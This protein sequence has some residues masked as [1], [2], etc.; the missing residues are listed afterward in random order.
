M[1]KI[2]VRSV[3]VALL[4]AACAL[5]ALSTFGGCTADKPEVD[6]DFTDLAGIDDK[7]DYFSSKLKVLGTLG[8]GD[9]V[10][11]RY[12]ATPRFRGYSFTAAAG[13][14]VDV[15]VKS[16]TGDALAWV[17]DG[18]Y[19]V[20]AKNDDASADTYDAHVVTTLPAS[21]VA[22]GRYYVIFRDYNLETRYFNVSLK[23]L[24]GAPGDAAWRGQAQAEIVRLVNDFSPLEAFKVDKAT[25]PAA[26]KARFDASAAVLETPWAYQVPV[27]GK[28]VYLVLATDGSGE[29]NTVVADL[30]DGAGV[31]FA[32]GVG[33]VVWD[34]GGGLSWTLDLADPT[35]C[36]CERGAGQPATCTWWADGS[37]TSSSEITCE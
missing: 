37:R 1:R 26:A 22:G 20:V 34:G 19:K 24:A 36:R 2:R 13:D 30:V 6:E 7:G 21:G 12:T 33:H 23:K 10:R 27:A 28:P 31:W 29:G 32:H 3:A 16:T 8:D 11:A 5:P 4:L 35:M 25:I 15:W 18:T 14:Q 17:V 9:A